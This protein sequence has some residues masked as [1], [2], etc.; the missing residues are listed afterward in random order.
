MVMEKRTRDGAQLP[1]TSVLPP[2]D[3]MFK[4]PALTPH[5]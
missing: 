3:R 1:G 2:A 5:A 4:K